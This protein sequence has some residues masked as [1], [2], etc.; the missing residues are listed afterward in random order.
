MSI[1]KKK[2]DTEPMM[3][4]SLEEV[5]KADRTQLAIWYRH[6]PPPGAMAVNTMRWTAVREYENRILCR[7]AARFHT[8]GGFDPEL[9]KVVG[10]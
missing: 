7:I 9:S 3:Y 10:W 8:L 4:P 5:V 2:N 1:P 6:L